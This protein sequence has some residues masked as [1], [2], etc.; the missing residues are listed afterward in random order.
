MRLL[1]SKGAA[2]HSAA[3]FLENTMIID[4]MNNAFWGKVDPRRKQ[5]RTDARMIS[6]DHTAMANLSERPVY[7]EFNAWKYPE[8]FDMYDQSDKSKKGE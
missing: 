4:E 5:E 2:Y 6:E 8:R 7:R 1:S 3:L